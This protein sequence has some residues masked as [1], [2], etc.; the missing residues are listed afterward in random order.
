MADPRPLDWAKAITDAEF[1]DVPYAA[2]SNLAADL[3]A[4]RFAA[5][6]GTSTTAIQFASASAALVTL[7]GTASDAG[8]Y[9]L[10]SNH[11]APSFLA[12]ADK[13][14]K[15]MDATSFGSRSFMM[16][17]RRRKLRG[18]NNSFCF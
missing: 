10:V 16:W 5:T 11:T 1:K 12:S 13:V 15:I 2:P 6:P 8:A 17:C 3:A 18:R 9:M 14:S 7:T 4:T